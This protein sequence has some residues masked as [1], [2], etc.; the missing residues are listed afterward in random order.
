VTG[1][2]DLAAAIR[3]VGVSDGPV[4]LISG[5]VVSTGVVVRVDAGDRQLACAPLVSVV[6]GETVWVLQ[7]G[8][9]NLIIGEDQATVDYA[10][11]TIGGAGEPAFGA[12][13]S[14][15]GGGFAGAR[16]RRT[17]DRRVE[18]QGLVSNVGAGGTGVFTLPVGYRPAAQLRF[19]QYVFRAVSADV[20][21]GRID[22]QADGVIVFTCT[23]GSGAIGNASI[24]CDFGLD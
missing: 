22:V 5:V 12:G 19:E 23:A 11:H 13:W 17:V 14:N 1:T 10:W 21:P 9:T 15:F 20:D 16:F 18:V 2:L 6:A 7:S 8:L 4:R 3:T 24:T